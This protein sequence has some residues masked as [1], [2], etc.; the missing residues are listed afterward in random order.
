MHTVFV[1][2]RNKYNYNSLLTL[3]AHLKVNHSVVLPKLEYC[4]AV[5]D[6]HQSILINELE[7]LQGFAGK[8]VTKD[9]KAS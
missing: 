1:F 5:W 9:W 3:L 8:V 6:P 7:K 2:L 4:T